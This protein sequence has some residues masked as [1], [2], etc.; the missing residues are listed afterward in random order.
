MSAASFPAVRG[1]EVIDALIAAIDAH[2]AELSE[3][4]GA[5]GDGD[6]GINMR[7]GFLR[8]RERLDGTEDLATGLAVIGQTLLDEIGGAMG[9]LYGSFFS[10]M[11]EACR[12]S[13]DIDALVLG[14]A[15]DAGLAVV[16]DLGGASVGDKTLL[17]T[18]VPAVAAF[19]AAV[20]AGEPFGDALAAMAAAAEAGKESTRGLVARVGRAS[21]LGERS[22]GVLDAG[23]TSCWLLLDAMATS[24]RGLL[25][26]GSPTAGS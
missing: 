12:G 15:L 26:A 21:R 10:E 20:E 7:K 13:A 4:D 24:M 14:R 3:I 9:P 19:H 11:G 22:R 2:A 6:H 1:R 18:L 16:R 8:A 5:I 17:D 25:G 23:A